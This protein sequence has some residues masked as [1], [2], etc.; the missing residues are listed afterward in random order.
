MP[1]VVAMLALKN[2]AGS[3]VRHRAPRYTWI[4]VDRAKEAVHCPVREA[5]RELFPAA[6][7]HYAT[8]GELIA[9]G[10]RRQ[11]LPDFAGLAVLGIDL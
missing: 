10:F 1:V 6:S 4:A 3:I 5:G 8:I 7:R 9:L 11:D 2:S